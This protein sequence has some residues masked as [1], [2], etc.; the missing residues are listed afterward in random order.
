MNFEKQLLL[1]IILGM[2]MRQIPVK[3]DATFP[4]VNLIGNESFV[5]KT[6]WHHYAEDGGVMVWARSPVK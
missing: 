4:E 2:G 3:M 5:V 6:T 1:P